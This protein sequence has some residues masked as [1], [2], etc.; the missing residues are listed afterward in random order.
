[1]GPDG[2]KGVIERGGLSDRESGFFEDFA[3]LRGNIEHW[4]EAKKRFLAEQVRM[5]GKLRAKAFPGRAAI[6]VKLLGLNEE[7]ISAVYEKPGSLK[8]GHYLPGTRIP[9][10]SDEDLF[11]LPDKAL[12]LLNLAWHIPLEIRSYMTEHGYS[13]PIIDILSTEDFASVR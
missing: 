9:I 10:R 1:M 12:P 7:S 4:R 3:L 6:L 11:A 2:G 13:G 8:I 5:H